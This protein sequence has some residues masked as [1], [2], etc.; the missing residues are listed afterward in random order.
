MCKYL[1]STG[2]NKIVIKAHIFTM[3]IFNSAGIVLLIMAKTL[4]DIYMVTSMLLFVHI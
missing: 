1:H 2:I 3:I 4:L